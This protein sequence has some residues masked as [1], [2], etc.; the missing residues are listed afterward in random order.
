MGLTAEM[1]RY[2]LR[3]FSVWPAL[4]GAYCAAVL[5]FLVIPIF[6]VVPLSFSSD[7]FLQYPI[8]GLSLRWYEDF[9]NSP[10]WIPALRNSLLVGIATA[11]I[12]TPLGALAAIG[13]VRLGARVRPLVLGLLIAPL[14]VPGIVTAIGMYFAFAPLGLTS[15]YTG[16]ILS[17]TAVSTPFVVIVVAAALQG[18][19]P[20]LIRAGSSLGAGPL[21]VYLRVVLPVIAPAVVAGAIFAFATSFDEV[22]ISL[23]LAGPAQR[24]LPLQMFDGVR[25]QISPTITAAATL[26]IA[27]SVLLLAAAEVLRRRAVR[28]RPRIPGGVK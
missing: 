23:F 21:T 22:I 24:T 4:L 3:H 25:E 19:D 11:L 28:A 10:R 1:A 27:I 18:F 26:V 8:P 17:H 16:L 2:T 6:A 13:I 7:S 14:I 20:N 12:A 15:S 5:G 9:F